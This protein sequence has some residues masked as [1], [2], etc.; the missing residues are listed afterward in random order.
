MLLETLRE[1]RDPPK[2]LKKVDGRGPKNLAI[3]HVGMVGTDNLFGDT[4]GEGL[5]DR[6]DVLVE[7]L[8]VGDHVYIFNHP[9]YK[10]FHPNDS[11]TGEH[12]L[13]YNCGDRGVKSR[14]GYSFG[15]HGKEGTVY[16]FYDDFLVDLLTDLHRAFRIGAIF[17]VWKQSGGTTVPF[18]DVIS[19]T[20][21]FTG[22]DGTTFP[23]RPA[24]VQRQLQV[25]GLH[26]DTDEGQAEADQERD[27]VRHRPLRDEERLRDRQGQD[28]HRRHQGREVHGGHPVRRAPLTIRR[29]PFDPVQWRIAYSDHS[30][31]AEQRYPVF[32]KESGKLTFRPL[33][34][35][36][37]FASPFG[38]RDPKKEQIATTRPRVSST[39]AYK[40]F[41]STNGAI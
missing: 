28:A 11:W 13:V 19:D 35:D 14:S 25:P 22:A 18:A 34:I 29:N 2:L 30:T 33:T 20:Q 7:D 16:A 6:A 17:L 23:G 4:S 3:H 36:D 15:G 1:A 40:S 32:T 37:L 9:L 26:E 38:K 8:V 31:N 10:V 27:A 5:F 24:P 39:A 41:L 21:D 12:S